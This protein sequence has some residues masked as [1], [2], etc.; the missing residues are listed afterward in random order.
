MGTEIIKGKWALVTGAS[1]GFGV[2]FARE[3][4]RYG[5][6]LI[7][8]ARRQ[9]R[10][11]GLK[12]ELVQ[13]QGISVEVIPKDLSDVDAPLQLFNQINS[14]GIDV[15][16]LINN[17]GFGLFGEF[18][19]LDWQD[20]AE[21]LK[22]NIL[23][24]TH[25]T[26]LFVHPMIKRGFGYILQVASNSAYQPSPLY[27]TYGASKSYVLNFSEALHNELRDTGVICSVISPGPVVTEFQEV[28]G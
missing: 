2:E 12:E 4:A 27:A 11:E 14:K 3:L 5:S 21:M 25:L 24:L 17:A 22:L 1:S 19:D 9:E 16:V 23:S 10:L 6:N 18:V 20:Q 28:A 7:I 26:W 13:N 8:T 15:D